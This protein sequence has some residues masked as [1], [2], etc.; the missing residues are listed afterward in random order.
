MNAHT[1]T[2]KTL[3]AYYYRVGVQYNHVFRVY[4]FCMHA[5]CM[6]AVC[7]HAVW[8]ACMHTYIACTH[9][10]ACN[11]GRSREDETR[12]SHR[13]TQRNPRWSSQVSFHTAHLK[14]D[15]NFHNRGFRFVFR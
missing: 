2:H 9:L 3:D 10:I 14:R 13:N 6:H 1:H 15:L 11:T 4:V 7:M 5:V 12:K 8:H